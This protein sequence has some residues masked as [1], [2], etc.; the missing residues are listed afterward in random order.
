MLKLIL[1]AI[2]ATGLNAFIVELLCRLQIRHITKQRS[3]SNL[4]TH[5]LLML[6]FLTGMALFVFILKHETNNLDLPTV[7]K[8]FIQLILVLLYLSP[9]IYIFDWRYPG[10][11]TKMENWRQGVSD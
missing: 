2:L 6:P 3:M 4:I 1:I 9:V 8:S 7:T 11:T 5:Y 10:L